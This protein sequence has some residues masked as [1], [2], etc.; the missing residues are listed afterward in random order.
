MHNSLPTLPGPLGGPAASAGLALAEH[1]QLCP[2]PLCLPLALQSTLRYP[3]VPVW[4]CR[5]PPP[6][7]GCHVSWKP[8]GCAYHTQAS[9]TPP[10]V[11]SHLGADV[12][13]P[14]PRTEATRPPVPPV[15]GPSFWAPRSSTR[16]AWMG[17][18]AEAGWTG[19]GPPGVGMAIST[20]RPGWRPQGSWAPRACLG[21]RG[22]L[23]PAS[24]W[25][26]PTSPVSRWDGQLPEAAGCGCGWG[27][28]ALLGGGC[29]KLG[30]GLSVG[31][32]RGRG[33]RLGS[34]PPFICSPAVAAGSGRFSLPSCLP[35]RPSDNREGGWR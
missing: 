32:P 30:A 18:W 33:G 29:G 12:C 28:G 4:P 14:V 9:R 25:S 6:S 10:A 23:G 8:W 26:T 1:L 35:T 5:P 17:L 13:P 20:L 16:Q 15:C 34:Q 27:A 2:D 22:S 7:P 24:T 11:G 21:L 3:S 31:A 19:Q